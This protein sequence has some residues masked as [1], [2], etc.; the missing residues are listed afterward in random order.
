MRCRSPHV[1]KSGKKGAS[2]SLL[3]LLRLFFRALHRLFPSSERGLRLRTDVLRARSHHP[4]PEKL[5]TFASSPSS[6]LFPSPPLYR[7]INFSRPS[8]SSFTSYPPDFLPR[9]PPLLKKKNG[10]R[11]CWQRKRPYSAPNMCHV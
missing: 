2:R 9:V 3:G 5:H 6:F 10:A 11:C 1:E 8:P 7:L 4:L